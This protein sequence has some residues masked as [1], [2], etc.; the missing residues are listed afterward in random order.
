MIHLFQSQKRLCNHKCLIVCL[1]VSHQNP[2]AS[3]KH[4]YQPNISISAIVPLSH[5]APTPLSASQNHN[6]SHHAYQ[7]SYLSAIVP[8]QESLHY[9]GLLSLTACLFEQVFCTNTDIE[10]F[11]E[12]LKY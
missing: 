12:W 10:M 9:L 7:L 8:I 1:S 4:A 5:H 2:S 11:L 3:Q 6:I